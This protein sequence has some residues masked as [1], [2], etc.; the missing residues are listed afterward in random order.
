MELTL[1]TMGMAAIMLCCTGVGFELA[2]RLRARVH[3]LELAGAVLD[4][5]AGE[6]SYRLT[7]PAQAVEILCQRPAFS[8]APY[9]ACCA[10]LGKKRVPF[11]DAWRQAIAEQ[12]DGLE[13]E[14]AQILAALAD[15]LGQAD[16]DGQLASIAHTRSLLA[17]QLTQARE[18]A[19]TH[20]GLYRTLGALTGAFFII[21]WI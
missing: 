17:V 7:P 16:L 15:T 11:P 18:R 2:G 8:R 13:Q 1:K 12:S 9:L 5:L 3:A 20:T 10:A 6:I 4:G 21:L 14:D 19:K